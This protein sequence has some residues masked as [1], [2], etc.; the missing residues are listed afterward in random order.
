[1]RSSRFTEEQIIAALKEHAAGASTKELCRRLGIA[2]ETR[3]NWKRKYGGR[4]VSEAR[5]LAGERRRFGY[6]RLHVML[7]REGQMV[8][9]KRVYRVYREEGL[10][11][12]KRS[13]KRVSREARVPLPAPLGA[14]QLWSLDFVSD[15]LSWGRRI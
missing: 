15:T 13:R 9:H 8:N 2:N 12:R 7:M 6:R 4:E 14:D 11:V 1:M 10:T 3:Y 5:Q